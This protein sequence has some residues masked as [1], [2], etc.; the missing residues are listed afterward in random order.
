[1]KEIATRGVVLQGFV[2]CCVQGQIQ[3]HLIGIQPQFKANLLESV[4]AFH[5]DLATFSDSYS[6]VSFTTD[7]QC[8]WLKLTQWC[9]FLV[10][11]RDPW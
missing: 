7:M 9:P 2:V 4:E 3:C 6:E 1:M 11:S 8:V 10:G 5:H